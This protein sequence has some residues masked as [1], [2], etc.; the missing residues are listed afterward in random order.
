MSGE[1][2]VGECWEGM[3]KQF[4]NIRVLEAQ[5]Q[6]L[7]CVVLQNRRMMIHFHS[8]PC[9][10]YVRLKRKPESQLENDSAVCFICHMTE[11]SYVSPWKEKI[12]ILCDLN[13]VSFLKEP[14]CDTFQEG[15]M[16]G[17]GTKAKCQSKSL[18][19]EEMI[20]CEIWQITVTATKYITKEAVLEEMQGQARFRKQSFWNL[21]SCLF[22]TCVDT[23]AVLICWHN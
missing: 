7:N 19:T 4:K 23:I 16:P 18:K 21:V 8:I 13:V 6:V 9:A 1:E 5:G 14:K 15:C 2:E 17:L 11:L 3:V 12:I 22:M 20:V 10:S